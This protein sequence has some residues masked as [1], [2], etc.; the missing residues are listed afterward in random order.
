MTHGL[1]VL[2]VP[3]PTP[4]LDRSNV[5]NFDRHLPTVTLGEANQEGTGAEPPASGAIQ[6]PVSPTSVGPIHLDAV[7]G[8]VPP[9][10]HQFRAEGVPTWVK[11]HHS[12][13]E[14][15]HLAGPTT[16]PACFFGRQCGIMH[17]GTPTHVI[18]GHGTITLTHGA[19][20]GLSL[21]RFSLRHQH[22][23]ARQP[24]LR[25]QPHQHPAPWLPC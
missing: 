3:H 25:Q 20:N 8:A 6:L 12:P 17:E 14:Q 18:L 13:A 9:S 24:V 1:P 7:G 5:V 4:I 19:V 16:A 22:R 10:P 21:H 23:C 2:H 11:G 15:F